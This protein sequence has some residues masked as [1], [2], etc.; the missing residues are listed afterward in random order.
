MYTDYGKE[1]Y[2]ILSKILKIKFAKYLIGSGIEFKG[3]FKI[4]NLQNGI[5]SYM[6]DVNDTQIRFHA[7]KDFLIFFMI[8]LENNIKEY[9]R[10]YNYLTSE[11]SDDHAVESA[12][13]DI[14]YFRMQ[15][16][17]LLKVMKEHYDRIKTT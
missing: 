12:Y 8:F 4:T 13:K 17:E 6:V 10:N 16:R 11:Y 1:T 2:N 15:H 9:D 14:D 7:L 3:I 5:D